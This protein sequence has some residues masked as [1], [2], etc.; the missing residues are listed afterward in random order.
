MN[1]VALRALERA[2]VETHTC[3]HDAREHHESTALWARWTMDVSAYVV[4]QE[5]GF[6]HNASLTRQGPNTLTAGVPVK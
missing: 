4:R 6:L 5:I 1:V 3:G 2:E